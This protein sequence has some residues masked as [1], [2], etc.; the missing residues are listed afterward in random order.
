MHRID[1]PTA[2]KDKFGAGK[3]GFTGGNPQTGELP[4]ALDADFFDSL[5]EEIARVIEAAG[6]TLKKSNNAQLLEAMN[7][8]T[9]PGRLLNVFLFT[10]SGSYTPSQGTKKIRVTVIG[11]G[12]G[13]GAAQSNSQGYVSAGSGGGAGGSAISELNVSDITLPVNVTVG[14]GGNRG[15]FS[16]NEPTS[17]GASSF[18][19]YLTASGG[20]YGVNGSSVA[21]GATR[22]IPNGGGG[23]GSNG[24]IISAIGGPGTPAIVLQTGYESGGGGNSLLSSGGT[25][26]STTSSLNGVNGRHGSGGGGAYVLSSDSE[27]SGGMG[28]N[29]IVIIEEYA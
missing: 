17:G 16:T 14:I 29:G 2:Q 26:I 25:P 23:A 19:T 11:G 21:F 27:K 8:L 13:G 12:G 3:N 28:G 6:L 7:T 20:Q 5:Q 22:L 1:T 10:A 9:G 18:G 24:N 15:V 4:T